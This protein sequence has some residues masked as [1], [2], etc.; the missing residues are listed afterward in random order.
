VGNL[1]GK[2]ALVTGSGRGIGRA[3]ALKLARE[4]SSVVIND[5]D[6]GPAEETAAAVRDIGGKAHVVAG[7]VTDER[8]A[9]RFVQTALS[10]FGGIDIIVNNAGFAWDSFIHKMSDDQF[11]TM[12]DVHLRAPFRVLRAASEYLRDTARKEAEEGREVFRKVVN[13]SSIAGLAG[14]MGQ[15]NYSAAKAGIVGI[16]KSLSREWGRSRVN[17]NCVAFGYI[18]TRLTEASDERKSI[19]VENKD[20]PVGIPANIAQQFKSAIPLGRPGT[21]EEAADGV[22]LFCTPESNYISGQVILVGGGP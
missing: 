19:K 9:E 5:L 6:E 8:F 17:V 2:V 18:E 7:S 16:T 13:I 4:G 20:V 11:D 15:S 1:E 21:P 3:L 22:Y 10:E 14:N 12:I